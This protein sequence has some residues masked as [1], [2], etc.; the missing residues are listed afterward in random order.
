MAT[1]HYLKSGLV[2]PFAT[3]ERTDRGRFRFGFHL[4]KWLKSAL[5][6][7]LA[8]LGFSQ[9]LTATKSAYDAGSIA[10][11]AVA[12]TTLTITG[13][14]VGDVVA[15]GVSGTVPTGI[16]IRVQITATNTATITLQNVTAGSID[17]GALDIKVKVIK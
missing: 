11:D 3:E 7:P 8:A 15:F 12:T 1:Q 5:T 14:A 16:L 6:A 4:E 17:P 9:V 2:E 13:A 10:T